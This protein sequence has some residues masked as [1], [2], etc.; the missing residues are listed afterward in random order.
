MTAATPPPLF[1]ILSSTAAILGGASTIKAPTHTRRRSLCPLC[2]QCVGY[3]ARHSRKPLNLS[4][5]PLFHYTQFRSAP[6]ASRPCQRLHPCRLLRC[7]PFVPFHTG[8]AIKN[9]NAAPTSPTLLMA[10]L[11]AFRPCRRAPTSR[12]IKTATRSDAVCRFASCGNKACRGACAAYTAPDAPSSHLTGSRLA[13]YMHC[14]APL[15][16]ALPPILHTSIRRAKAQ[17]FYAFFKVFLFA[18]L[19]SAIFP[20]RQ[21]RLP[22]FLKNL[23]KCYKWSMRRATLG[24]VRPLCALTAAPRSVAFFCFGSALP[25]CKPLHLSRF[26][27]WL[28]FALFLRRRQSRQR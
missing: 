8:F 27:L 19:L 13:R 25:R 3:K 2:R 11:C 14:A 5:S 18:P 17:S 10:H 26:A 9:Y 7:A 12:G 22:N 1:E 16:P 20:R 24:R 23:E 4:L 28:R 6:R 21:P 15:A